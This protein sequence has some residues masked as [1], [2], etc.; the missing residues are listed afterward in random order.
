MSVLVRKTKPGEWLD[1]RKLKQ[2][3]NVFRENLGPN[4]MERAIN[5]LLRAGDIEF[6]SDKN[7]KNGKSFI[8]LAVEE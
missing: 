5:G 4:V 2:H 7:R 1:M 6:N 8:R 3:L